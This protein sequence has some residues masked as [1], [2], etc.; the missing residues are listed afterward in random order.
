[1]VPALVPTTTK[2]IGDLTQYG[3]VG[4]EKQAMI[5]L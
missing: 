2:L 5:H 1:M 4:N 3:T